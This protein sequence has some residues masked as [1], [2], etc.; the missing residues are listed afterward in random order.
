[1][2]LTSELAESPDAEGKQNSEQKGTALLEFTEQHVL[3]QTP[4]VRQLL[5]LLQGEVPRPHTATATNAEVRRCWK[6][7][8]SSTLCNRQRES[9]VRKSAGIVMAKYISYSKKVNGLNHKQTP[10]QTVLLTKRLANTSSGS[11]RG[12]SGHSGSSRTW[13]Q[14]QSPPMMWLAPR[15]SCGSQS[16]ADPWASRGDAS[17]P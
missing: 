2:L 6:K 7:T 9:R 15:T 14:I 12:T 13:D 8:E 3:P 5:A 1:M 11:S 17:G 16:L 10:N 4:H